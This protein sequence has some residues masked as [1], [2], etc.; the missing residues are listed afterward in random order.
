MADVAMA[1]REGL[2]SISESLSGD[3]RSSHRVQRAYLR[4]IQI[5]SQ[6]FEVPLA[7]HAMHTGHSNAI[8]SQRVRT[9]AVH[10]ALC[11]PAR[12]RLGLHFIYGVYRPPSTDFIL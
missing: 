5:A 2:R 1:A 11:P 9:G 8:Q 4:H 12:V 3:S 6:V 7:V 10:P